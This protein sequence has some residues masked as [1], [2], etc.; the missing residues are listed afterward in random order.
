MPQASGKALLVVLRAMLL[1][2]CGLYA[3]QKV[4]TASQCRALV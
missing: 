1:D 4:E 2:E 3:T